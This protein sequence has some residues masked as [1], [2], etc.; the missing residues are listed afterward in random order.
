[1]RS[2][3]EL[4]H[5]YSL[6]NVNSENAIV[7]AKFHRVRHADARISVIVSA[8]RAKET[9]ANQT[10]LPDLETIKPEAGTQWLSQIKGHVTYDVTRCTKC[11][12]DRPLASTRYCVLTSTRFRWEN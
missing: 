3:S 6:H 12:H 8:S 7:A 5:H 2:S 1:M 10:R 9:R 11:R 4:C